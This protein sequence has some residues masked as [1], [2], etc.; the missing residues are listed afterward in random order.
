MII[1]NETALL[2]T[3]VGA[4][5][6]V[7]VALLALRRPILFKMGARNIRKRKKMAALI[8][9][10]LMVSTAIISAGLAVGDSLGYLFKKSVY[11]SL[12]TVDEIIDGRNAVGSRVYFNYSVYQ[13]LANFS[14]N[15]S[16]HIRGISPAIIET[17][18][19]RDVTITQAEPSATLIGLDGAIE[20]QMGF[21]ALDGGNFYSDKIHQGDIVINKK[22]AD[23]LFGI[24]EGDQMRLTYG[25]ANASNPYK[26]DM[27]NITFNLTMILPD[28]KDNIGTANFLGGQNIFLNLSTVQQMFRRT[29][30][31]N[32]IRVSNTG[33]VYSGVQYSEGVKKALTDKL[34]SILGVDDVDLSIAYQNNSVTVSYGSGISLSNMFSTISEKH[35]KTIFNETRNVTANASIFE[36]ALVPVMRV[37]ST[38]VSGFVIGIKGTYAGYTIPEMNKNEMYILPLSPMQITDGAVVNVTAVSYDGS[39]NTSSYSVHLLADFV[40]NTLRNMSVQDAANLSAKIAG[41]QGLDEQ[42]SMMPGLNVTTITTLI[43]AIQSGALNIS[44]ILAMMM[45]PANVTNTTNTTGQASGM[46]G[47]GPLVVGLMNI[48][49]ARAVALGKRVFENFTSSI[50]ITNISDAEGATIVRR[51]SSTLNDSINSTDVGISVK[52]SK[53]LGI[54]NA[55]ESGKMIGTMFSIFGM[56]SIIAGIVLIINIFVMLAEERKSEMGMARAV[57]LKRRQLTQLFIF[58]GT[59]YSIAASFVGALFGIAIGYM[60]VATFGMIFTGMGM[61]F[62]IQFYFEWDSVITAFWLGSIITFFTILVTSWRVSNLNIVKAIRDIPDVVTEKASRGIM[63]LGIALTALGCLMAAAGYV[64]KTTAL[65]ISGPS[66]MFLAIGMIVMRYKSQRF[67]YT[68]AGGLIVLWMFNP[69]NFLGSTSDSGNLEVFIAAGVWLV[70]GAIMLVMFNSELFLKTVTAIFYKVKTLRA[71]LKIAVSYP[72]RKKFR[73]GMT[74]AMF[75]LIIF[76]ITVMS[77]I[78]AMMG[79]VFDN[80]LEKES[81]GYD[82]IAITNPNTPATNLSFGTLPANL[83]QYSISAIERIPQATVK[84]LVE[85]DGKN[86]TMYYSLLGIEGRDSPKNFITNSSFQFKEVAPEYKG[87]NASAIW[88]AVLNDS[89]LVVIDGLLVDAGGSSFDQYMMAGSFVKVKVGQNMTISDITTGTRNRTVRVIAALDEMYMFQGVLMQSDVVMNEYKGSYMIYMIKVD[90]EVDIKPVMKELKMEYID[91]GITVIGIKETVDEAMRMMKNIFY[92]MDAFLGLGLVVGIIGLGVITTRSIVERRREIGI[93]RAIGFKKSMIRRA[94]MVETSFIALTGIFLGL[95]LGISIAYI[96]MYPSGFK[97][98]GASFVVPWFDLA[99]ISIIAYVVT[100][101][102]TLNSAFSAAKIAPA[103]AIRYSE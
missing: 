5:L 70:S 6:F 29:G 30:Q 13:E 61:R 96:Q 72:M 55:E 95:F 90:N 50:Y 9:C 12:N 49:D 46:F 59:L 32:N 51:V 45:P 101:A 40:E 25:L 85:K 86:S 58:E 2:Y 74:L 20:R 44:G 34:D 18:A 21:W 89:S 94:F 57:G 75:T 52:E 77:M 54:K 76:T 99:V 102:S 3:E 53:R 48:T 4:I 19:I 33:D 97:S 1:I 10:G 39:L 36:E 79:T 68:L 87:M 8:V 78:A 64:G 38:N 92:L 31:I 98:M 16:I 63:Y 27:I 23:K 28:P 103:E 71:V 56:F 84:L 93:L 11:E 22:L 37:G 91:N 43:P 65:W 100:V 17:V 60:M 42:L 80:T 35:A 24:K 81:G 88:G 15:Q 66:L 62:D 82:I 41:I 73:T 26:P 7:V 69:I 47:A 83:S 14:S 67:A